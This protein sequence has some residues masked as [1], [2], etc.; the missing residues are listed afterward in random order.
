MAVLV[1]PDKAEKIH[2][3]TLCD[4]AAAGLIHQFLVGGS[5]LFHDKLVQTVDFLKS[6]SS[7]PVTIFP[8]NPSQIY[9]GADALLLLSLV[10]GRNADLLIGRHVESAPL[11]KK[12]GLEV[13]PT[14]YILMDGGRATAVSYISNT[15]PIPA[16]KPEIA[17]ATALAAELLGMR[18]VYLEAGSGA[19]E[20]VSEETVKAV[21]SAVDIPIIVGGGIRTA[22]QAHNLCLAG[23][24]TLVVGTA[25]ERNPHLIAEIAEGINAA[26][27]IKQG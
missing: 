10:S 6:N 1:D 5:L 27:A 2:L 3:E 4:F 11:L 26:N 22:E 14:A 8:G 12:S 25:F 7:N 18:C 13:I 23:A 17:A 24:N 20:A 9:S 15:T 21:R 19:K 16:H